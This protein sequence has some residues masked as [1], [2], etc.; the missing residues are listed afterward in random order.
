[1]PENEVQQLRRELRSLAKAVQLLAA[2]Q[3]EL[4]D[5]QSGQSLQGMG[6]VDVVHLRLDLVN[7]ENIAAQ[8]A[9]G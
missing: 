2:T 7:A 9:N 1:M 8:H 6:Q 5:R 4:L 3:R